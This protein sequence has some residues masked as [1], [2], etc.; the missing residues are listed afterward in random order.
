[1]YS[2]F[3]EREKRGARGRREFYNLEHR[4]RNKMS[5]MVADMARQMVDGSGTA[6]ML[7]ML[8]P[9]NEM[10]S[11]T[12]AG[13]LE[14]RIRKSTTFAR[15]AASGWGELIAVKLPGERENDA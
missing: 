8:S 10:A 13:E 11:P 4:L 15:S 7:S 6:V 2:G 9:P 14:L 1:M 12:I 5:P 3:C